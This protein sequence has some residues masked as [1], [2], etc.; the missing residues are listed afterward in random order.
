MCLKYS[1]G[2]P[3]AQSNDVDYHML[4]KILKFSTTKMQ[5]AHRQSRGL[6]LGCNVD[7]KVGEKRWTNDLEFVG[8]IAKK[9]MEQPTMNQNENENR[10]YSNPL[11]QSFSHN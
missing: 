7:L 4:T 11:Q 1:A 9:T 6:R 5:C 3:K 8:L 10:Q 2:S